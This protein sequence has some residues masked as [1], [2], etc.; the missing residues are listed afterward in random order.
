MATP[1]RSTITVKV[2]ANRPPTRLRG[3]RD[4]RY[5]FDV[6]AP[7]EKGRANAELIR[8]LAAEL[9]IP[10]EAVEIVA[11]TTSGIKRVRLHGVT[12]A[13]VRA[14]LRLA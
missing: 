3:E 13:G 8:F 12:E 5:V 2:H 10:R 7:A 6:A 14:A 1:A 4:G 11:G 9:R